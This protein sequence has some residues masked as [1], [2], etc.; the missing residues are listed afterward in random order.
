M[1]FLRGIIGKI[2]GLFGKAVSSAP[3]LGA[4]QNTVQKL[5]TAANIVQK[6]GIGGSGVQK[7]AGAISKLPLEEI[8]KTAQ[9]AYDVGKSIFETGKAVREAFRTKPAEPQAEAPK[10]VA[11]GGAGQPVVSLEDL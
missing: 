1:S 3:K 11:M 5:G 10:P 7:V 4:I 8:G 2:G 6:L 9:Q